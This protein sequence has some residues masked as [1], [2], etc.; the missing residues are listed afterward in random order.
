MNLCTS[1][2]KAKHSETAETKKLAMLDSRCCLLEVLELPPGWLLSRALK[3]RRPTYS[4][5][6]D[7]HRW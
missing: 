7:A 5:S 1:K 2:D 3:I 4:S 6:M